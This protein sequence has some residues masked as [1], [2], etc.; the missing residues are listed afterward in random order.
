MTRSELEAVFLEHLDVI[1]RILSALARRHALDGDDA[2]D[3]V[4]WV[5]ARI[6]E[7]DYAVLAKFRGE[8]ALSTYLTVAL[9]MLAR[10]YLARERGRWRPSAAAKRNGPVGLRLEALT[11]RNGLKLNVAG[12]MMRS[13]GQTSLSD[14]E[15]GRIAA[16]LPARASRQLVRDPAVVETFPAN[17]AADDLVR[18]GERVQREQVVRQA[19]DESLKLLS[20]EDALIVRLH[21]IEGLSIADVARSLVVPQKPLYRRLDRALALLRRELER[22]GVTRD[23][24]LAIVVER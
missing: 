19:L 5:K 11:Q 24:Y 12:E 9:S 10:E 8:S 22:R 6:V 17:D 1:E 18:H 13:A 20:N 14:A 7:S 21:F 15:L 3:L 23:E 4:G 16:Q 2:A